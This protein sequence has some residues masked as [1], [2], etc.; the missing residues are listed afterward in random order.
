MAESIPLLQMTVGAGL[1]SLMGFA[2]FARLPK[3]NR[4]SRVVNP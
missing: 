1:G 4:A 3:M 2:D